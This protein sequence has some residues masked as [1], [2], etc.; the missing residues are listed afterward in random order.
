MTLCI[1]NLKLSFG[2]TEILRGIDLDLGMGECLALVGESG[3][4]SPHW[5]FPS[6][7]FRK[8]LSR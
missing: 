2:R 7:A 3:R 6:W 1:R 8:V 5:D 4:E